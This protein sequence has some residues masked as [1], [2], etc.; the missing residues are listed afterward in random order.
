MTIRKIVEDIRTHAG[1]FLKGARLSPMVRLADVDGLNDVVVFRSKGG[2]DHVVALVVPAGAGEN[3]W[4][5]SA[6]APLSVHSEELPGTQW[7]LLHADGVAMDDI[8]IL[9][10][11]RSDE[12]RVATI[13]ENIVARGDAYV[14]RDDLGMCIC[15]DRRIAD[16][17]AKFHH[18][19][20]MAEGDFTIRISGQETASGDALADTVVLQMHDGRYIDV[21]LLP[22]VIQVGITSESAD[23]DF[24]ISDMSVFG[25]AMDQVAQAFAAQKADHSY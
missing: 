3:A 22:D 14:P 4:E 1:D 19:A 15:T 24:T 5:R 13:V 12:D 20:E 16:V 9:N 23:R 6:I 10:D 25:E 11:C 18:V 7:H 17:V 2:R 21:T 8:V